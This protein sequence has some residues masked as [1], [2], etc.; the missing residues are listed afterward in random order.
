MVIPHVALLANLPAKCVLLLKIT[1][2]LN[3][4]KS[5]LLLSILVLNCSL[6]GLGVV[7]IV[8]IWFLALSSSMISRWE[9]LREASDVICLFIY[10]CSGN[11]LC[12]RQE[13]V[14][15][16]SRCIHFCHLIQSE[17]WVKGC[18]LFSDW[19]EHNGVISRLQP[20]SVTDLFHLI[21][22]Y[23]YYSTMSWGQRL[24]NRHLTLL[25]LVC[26]VFEADKSIVS[27]LAN[28]RLSV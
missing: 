27:A 26:W 10:R 6:D 23:Y 4:L 16:S 11:W 15:W 12:F 25:Q 3:R 7:A 9:D 14:V 21:R 17:F 19:V 24:S 1:H 13:S 8:E 20:C 22:S 5:K 18:W 2:R 28:Q